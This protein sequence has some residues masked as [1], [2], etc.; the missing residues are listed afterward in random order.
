MLQQSIHTYIYPSIKRCKDF[1]IIFFGFIRLTEYHSLLYNEIL[2][3][4]QHFTAIH[5]YIHPRVKHFK[6][7]NRIFFG[8]IR[9]IEH[10]SFLYNETLQNPQHVTA[11]HTCI[12]VLNTLRISTEYFLVLF[13]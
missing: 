3:N 5:T 7:F 1:D 6:D 10:D 4:P 9:L 2:Q 8:F 13:G 11:I 12:H